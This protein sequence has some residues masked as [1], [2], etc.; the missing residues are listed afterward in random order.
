[1]AILVITII[2]NIEGTICWIMIF[3]LFATLAGVGGI[4]AFYYLKSSGKYKNN[5][6]WENPGNLKM[7]LIL[8][9]PFFLGLVEGERT[10]S[11]KL[12]SISESV[13]IASSSAVVWKE[14]TSHDIL[15]ARKHH[16]TLSGLMGFPGHIST[17]LDTL[18]IGGKRIARYEKGL[19]FEE[20]IADYDPE[21]LLVLDIKTDP[22]KIP[23]TVMD[24][25]ILIGGRHVDI[26]QD[27]YKIESL[28]EG[29][30]RLTLTSNFSINTPF[31]WYAGIWASGL[32]AD[33]LHQQLDLIK[34]KAMVAYRD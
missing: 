25:H 33:I 31:N 18:S 1:M 30:C 16:T 17:T 2:A 27:A 7:S 26:L 3:P 21:K 8:L 34:D 5:E 32:M 13:V 14:L 6:D 12:F 23:P 11:E 15:E 22:K 10:S 28:P 19:Y 4:I 24:E 20:T 9:L 29:K